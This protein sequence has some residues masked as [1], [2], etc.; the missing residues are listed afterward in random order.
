MHSQEI[1]DMAVLNPRELIIEQLELTR[2]APEGE[3]K[4]GSLQFSTEKVFL[5]ISLFLQYKP[6][7]P[8]SGSGMPQ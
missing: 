3:C 8:S 5:E 4:L 2:K 7:Y 1:A 6:A